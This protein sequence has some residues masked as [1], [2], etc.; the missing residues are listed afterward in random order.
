MSVTLDGDLTVPVPLGAP[1]F[2]YP[3]SNFRGLQHITQEYAVLS[4]EVPPPPL[5]TKHHIYSNAICAEQSGAT[6]SGIISKFTRTFVNYPR[7]TITAK[8]WNVEGDASKIT[9]SSDL[10]PNQ[11]RQGFYFSEELFY[12]LDLDPIEY[13]FGA[14]VEVTYTYPAFDYY[15]S[16]IIGEQTNTINEPSSQVKHRG[17]AP[18]TV[19][20]MGLETSMFINLMDSKYAEFISGSD[21][22]IT[23]NTK[24]YYKGEIY[25]PLYINQEAGTVTIRVGSENVVLSNAQLEVLLNEP[26]G[27]DISS[28]PIKDKW[29]PR[30][31]NYRVQPLGEGYEQ[32]ESNRLEV[33]K[34]VG[35][36][37]TKPNIDQ[38]LEAVEAGIQIRGKT[39]RVEQHLGCIYKIVETLIPLK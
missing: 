33:A 21:T 31:V 20:V 29:I 22:Q 30:K 23:S 14:P 15:D 19:T 8:R 32:V 27:F 2:S 17:R 4:T 1:A 12:E 10:T 24:I 3:I 6:A 28:I 35:T 38:Y 26:S 5:G 25:S 16:F 9:I 34:A 13:H 37:Y 39:T 7:S 11:R 36:R 18:Y